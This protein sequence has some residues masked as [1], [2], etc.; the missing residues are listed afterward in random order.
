MSGAR[1]W[2]DDTSSIFP[3]YLDKTRSIYSLLGLPRSIAKAFGMQAM[4]FYGSALANGETIP[5]FFAEDDA[6][7]LG[8]DFI[9]TKSDEGLKFT[10]IYRS[11]HSSD[12]PSISSLLECV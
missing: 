3:L 7:Q 5:K 12:R 1:Q 8:G 10:L 4:S 9:L 2:L 11:Q 6:H